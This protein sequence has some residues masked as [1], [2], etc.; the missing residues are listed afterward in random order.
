MMV[1]AI[2]MAGAQSG[3]AQNALTFKDGSFWL[4]GAGRGLQ[5]PVVLPPSRRLGVFALQHKDR[6]VVVDDRGLTVRVGKDVRTTRLPDIAVTGKLFTRDEVLRTVELVEKG[7][8]TRGFATW[9]GDARI[10]DTLYLLLRWSDKAGT[11]WL[12]ALVDLDLNSPRPWPRLLGRFPAPSP[13]RNEAR[14]ALRVVDGKLAAIG[15]DG[16]DWGVSLWN[17]A[18]PPG[19]MARLGT[20]TPIGKGLTTFRSSPD[21]SRVFAVERTSYGTTLVSEAD[22]VSRARKALFEERGDVTL[23]H[24]DPPV[25]R[26]ARGE[27]TLLRNLD[28]GAELAINPRMTMRFLESGMLAWFPAER[29]TQAALYSYSDWRASASWKAATR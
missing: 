14:D 23:A 20:F 10:G 9:A 6:W 13:R 29:P 12:E 5:I 4:N 21:L 26:F 28:T 15:V 2:L 27:T 24:V 8:R 7:E 19:E 3:V 25:A 16:D 11:P 22:W 1:A 18:D 17:P